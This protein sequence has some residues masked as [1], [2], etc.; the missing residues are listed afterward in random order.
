[1]VYMAVLMRTARPNSV[2]GSY[3]HYINDNERNRAK[4]STFN[5]DTHNPGRHTACKRYL[6]IEK[7]MKFLTKYGVLLFTNYFNE[8]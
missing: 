4:F 6:L 8:Q 3:E 5:V 1:M 7:L 2:P